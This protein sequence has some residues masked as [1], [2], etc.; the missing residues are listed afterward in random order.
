M[1]RS[2]CRCDKY[3]QWTVT[4]MTAAIRRR[5]HEPLLT[6][7]DVPG[8][9]IDTTTTATWLRIHHLNRKAKITTRST[10]TTTMTTTMTERQDSNTEEQHKGTRRFWARPKSQLFVSSIKPTVKMDDAPT[11]Q[12]RRSRTMK[13]TCQVVKTK[14]RTERSHAL[15]G[16]RSPRSVKRGKGK[17]GEERQTPKARL[18]REIAK[19]DDH[20]RCQR[21]GSSSGQR[22]WK[23]VLEVA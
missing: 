10:M 6:I 13:R 4:G 19:A 8:R 20:E 12:Q 22:P 7:E 3:L 5:G 23:H 18:R 14:D 9:C 11:N 17:R 15:C 2:D 16:D 21:E 1:S